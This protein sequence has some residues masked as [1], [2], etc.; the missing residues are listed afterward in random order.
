MQLALNYFTA[1]NK[2]YLAVHQAK[3]AL[4]W[5]NYMGLGGEDIAQHSLQPRLFISVLLHRAIV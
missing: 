5:Q 2:D 3:E 1:L 4:Y